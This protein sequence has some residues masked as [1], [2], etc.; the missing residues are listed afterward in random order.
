[1]SGIAQGNLPSDPPAIAD[2]APANQPVV[3][4]HRARAAPAGAAGGGNPSR[5]LLLVAAVGPGLTD[6]DQF[7][8]R[9]VLVQGGD[10]CP[11]FR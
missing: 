1:M 2:G 8:E 11:V 3:N 9:D 6:L 4:S 7:V 10:R 5:A